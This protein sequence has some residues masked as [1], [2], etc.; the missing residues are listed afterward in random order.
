MKNKKQ[1]EEK[2]LKRLAH[3]RKIE[4]DRQKA[5]KEGHV[6]EADA[7]DNWKEK[8]DFEN[9]NNKKFFITF[10]YPYMNGRLH[11]GHAFSLSRKIAFG[12][13]FLN[14]QM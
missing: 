1:K 9:K 5:W 6:F 12:P 7:E 2:A 10:P 13:W 14:V 4:I 11:L 3:L 8:Y